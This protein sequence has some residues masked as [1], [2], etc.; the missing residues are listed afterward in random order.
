MSPD[1]FLD[2]C[3]RALCVCVVK[4]ELLQPTEDNF[5]DSSTNGTVS[6]AHTKCTAQA[7]LHVLATQ[8]TT[9]SVLA[10]LNWAPAALDT[11]A[12]FGFIDPYSLLH[13]SISNTQRS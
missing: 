7:V 2:D 12:K 8:P 6:V 13:G 11:H 1:V 5:F 10:T 3:R 9:F 4:V